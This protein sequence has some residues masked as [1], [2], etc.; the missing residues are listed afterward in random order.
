MYH[1]LCRPDRSKSS[2]ILKKKKWHLPTWP[3]FYIVA[4]LCLYTS[5]GPLI[6]HT[7]PPRC[8]GDYPT[9]TK[10]D[11]EKFGKSSLCPQSCECVKPHA[12]L[13]SYSYMEVH[14]HKVMNSKLS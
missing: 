1:I 13:A 9:D 2:S 11:V 5:L 10:V 4:G 7:A 6:P 8:S 3:S 14:A 12:T